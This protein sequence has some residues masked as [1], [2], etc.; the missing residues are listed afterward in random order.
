MHVLQGCLKDYHA[1]ISQQPFI[2][3]NCNERV[4]RLWIKAFLE[5]MPAIVNDFKDSELI[6]MLIFKLP[7]LC[8]GLQAN[9]KVAASGAISIRPLS[10]SFGG[11]VSQK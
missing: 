1:L 6:D 11:G 8:H 2:K 3:A 7:W 9:Y 10:S 4:L 5:L